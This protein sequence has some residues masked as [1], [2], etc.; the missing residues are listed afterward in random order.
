MHNS[1]K[2]FRMATL[3]YCQERNIQWEENQIMIASTEVRIFPRNSNPFGK[4]WE[5]WTTKWWQ[6][7]LSIPRDINPGYGH[8]HSIFQD[9]ETVYFLAGTFGGSANRTVTIPSE[10]AILF[11]IINF[12]TSY[13]ED[14]DLRDDQHMLAEAKKDIDDIVEKSL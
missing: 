12:T 2:L 7:I 9:N 10:R 14:S 13:A 11:P 6:W 3:N 8:D 5:E 1:C 4:N